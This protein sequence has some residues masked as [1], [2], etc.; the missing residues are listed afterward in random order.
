MVICL[1]V[2]DTVLMGVRPSEPPIP[3]IN[4]GRAGQ[5]VTY[6]PLRALIVCKIS[7]SARSMWWP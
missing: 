2:D 5:E 1:P 4:G 7:K 3:P 6:L